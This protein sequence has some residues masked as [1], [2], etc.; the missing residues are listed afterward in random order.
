VKKAAA[1]AVEIGA[2]VDGDD[3]VPHHVRAAW[4]P[5]IDAARSAA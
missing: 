4:H 5:L 1:F 2:S 3:E